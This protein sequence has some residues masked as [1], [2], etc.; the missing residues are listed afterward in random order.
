MSPKWIIS[1]IFA[2]SDR[3]LIRYLRLPQLLVFSSIQPVMF[4]LL[5]AYVFGGAIKIPGVDYI[6]FLI[7]GIIVQTVIFGSMQ[8][9]VGLADDL[10]HGM[11]DRF[12]SLPMSRSAVLAGRTLADGIRNIF[13]YPAGSLKP[14]QLPDFM[15][16]IN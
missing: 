15:Q 4:L 2:I 7:P 16:K 8:T 11:I 13:V 12:R 14:F 1:D 5:F 10:M 6:D 9:G 3:N